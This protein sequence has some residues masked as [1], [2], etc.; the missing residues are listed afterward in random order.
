MSGRHHSPIFR[1]FVCPP[2][3][4]YSLLFCEKWSGSFYVHRVWLSYTRDWRL[5]VSSERQGNEDKAPCSG[6]QLPSQ[7][8]N[9]GPRVWES[10]VLSARPLWSYL[11]MLTQEVSKIPMRRST[12]SR[13]S[14]MTSGGARMARISLRLSDL[15]LPTALLAACTCSHWDGNYDWN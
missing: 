3:R 2:H 1:M 12:P 4:G 13:M 8:S 10:K 7:G 5:K 6:A 9:R 11:F 14:L 15:M